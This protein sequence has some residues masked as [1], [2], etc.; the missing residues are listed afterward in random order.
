VAQ[1][2]DIYCR[3]TDGKDEYETLYFDTRARFLQ[4]SRAL[5]I[6]VE[7]DAHFIIDALLYSL[8]AATEGPLLIQRSLSFTS[9]RESFEMS[10]IYLEHLFAKFATED[11]SEN[12]KRAVCF[13]WIFTVGFTTYDLSERENKF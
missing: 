3:R 7:R 8:P 13:R 5:E 12:V 4:P 6:S 2:G 9:P 11:G 1:N 10:F